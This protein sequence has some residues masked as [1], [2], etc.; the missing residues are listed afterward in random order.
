MTTEE[1]IDFITDYEL[2]MPVRAMEQ[3]IAEGAA[4]VPALRHALEQWQ[5][6]EDCDL[7]WIVV[8]LGELRDPSAI[9]ILIRQ[10]REPEFDYLAGAA[11]EALAKLGQAAVPALIAECQSADPMVRLLAYAT[12]GWI[13]DERCFR[14]LTEALARDSELTDVIATALTDQ[15]RA[16]A[17]PLIFEVY[18]KVSPWQRAE[19]EEAIR[20]LHRQLRIRPKWKKDWRLR[21]R[22][23]G[24]WSR[25]DP[26]WPA[27]A[28]TLHRSAQWPA[29]R[30]NIPLRSLEEIIAADPEPDAAEESC[31]DCGAPLE[32]P[33][34]V[35]VCPETALTAAI[36]QLEMLQSWRDAGFEDLFD[37]LNELDDRIVEARD[38]PEAK[39]RAK[40]E[41]Q[42]SHLVGLE[43]ERDTCH[44]L[45]EQGH[46]TVGQAKAFMLAQAALLAHRY[47]DPD[48]LMQPIKAPIRT[49][50]KV[51][52]NDPCPC[53]SGQKYKRCCLGKVH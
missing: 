33:T 25:F 27:I 14:T 26:D 29:I 20:T 5:D 7:I 36:R 4:A 43:V 18:Q 50:N 1:L 42:L 12:L 23:S 47:G 30:E 34:G 31:E 22:P 16:E 52:R 9:E 37:A 40:R 39:A 19:L 32:Y 46:E 51:G 35:P 3:L 28:N 15:G 24:I 11:S 2:G 17:L 48:G 8:V 21:Y 10:L 44:W 13:D 45:I 41:K 6:D 49:V 53:G 38:Q